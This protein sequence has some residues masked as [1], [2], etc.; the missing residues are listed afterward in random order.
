M[1]SLT[2]VR[3]HKDYPLVEVAVLELYGNPVNWLAEVDQSAF[4]PTSVAPNE[5]LSPD[6][7]QQVRILAP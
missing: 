4:A 2:K 7:M 1:E 6:K 3:S 5:G